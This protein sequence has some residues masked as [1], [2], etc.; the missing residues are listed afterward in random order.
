MRWAWSSVKGPPS[1]RM[2][3][4]LE[5]YQS[6]MAE[7]WQTRPTAINMFRQQVPGGLS[8]KKTQTQTI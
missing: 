6:S 4:P 2:I 7:L 8:L 1:A 3:Q 5:V